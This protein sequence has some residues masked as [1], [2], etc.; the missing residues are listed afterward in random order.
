M[1]CV[2]PEIFCDERGRNVDGYREQ[3]RVEEK[4]RIVDGYREQGRIE[5]K[6]SFEDGIRLVFQDFSL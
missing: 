6:R 4:G 5:E 3:G 1:F 2:F